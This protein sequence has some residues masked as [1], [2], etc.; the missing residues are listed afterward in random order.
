MIHAG[1]AAEYDLR[2]RVNGADVSHCAAEYS[3][4]LLRRRAVLLVPH[5]ILLHLTAAG[6][7]ESFGHITGVAAESGMKSG[8]LSLELVKSARRAGSI[9]VPIPVSEDHQRLKPCPVQ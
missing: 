9:V 1:D 8:I 2:R 7:A 5:L 6:T 3:H 4:I